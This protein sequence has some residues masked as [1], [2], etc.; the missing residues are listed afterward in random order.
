M[1]VKTALPAIAAGV[2]A[3]SPAL[4]QTT[5]VPPPGSRQVVP[6]KQGAPLQS[7]RS[8]S[9]S[10]KLEK[11]DGVIRPQENVDP[12]MRAPAPNAQTHSTPVIPPSATGGDTAK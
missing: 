8:E 2:L 6:E 10:K 11:S 12:G 7:G 5:P 9:L 3:I 1:K 4:A